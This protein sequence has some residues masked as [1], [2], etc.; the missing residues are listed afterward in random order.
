MFW[1]RHPI[2][3]DNL[4]I[5]VLI[6]AYVLAVFGE[7]VFLGLDPEPAFRYHFDP[8]A[9][10]AAVFSL[11]SL[12]VLILTGSHRRYLTLR[13]LG[14]FMVV[15]AF[16]PLFTSSF[17]TCKQI[18]PYIHPFTWDAPL[19]RLDYLVHFGN[20]PWKLFEWMFDYPWLIRGIDYAYMLWFGFI[21]LFTVWM[22]WTSHRRIRLC[23]FLTTVLSWTFL[24]S[25]LGTVF[26][27]AGPCYYSK[28]ADAASDPFAPLMSRLEDVNK[29]TPL[30]AIENQT[31]LW[32]ASEQREW[33]P[34][35]GVSAMPS[36]HVAMAAIFALAAFRVKRWLGVFFSGYLVLIQ[37]GA[38]ILGW[39]YAV[40]G[41]FSIVI[42]WLIWALISWVLNRY[43]RD[44][45]FIRVDPR[46][47]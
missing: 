12:A 45:A 6:S 42:T 21:I 26:S 27:S 1:R 35:G 40:D 24:G 41:Y 11:A 33:I 4:P 43:Q 32:E 7:Q 46:Y 34:Y 20:H 17:N 44:P 38:V 9:R 28:V 47:E 14:G 29:R 39:H 5:V 10:I 8:F 13:Y 23:F 30:Y 25:F 37:I 36:I 18:I 22:A 3:T 16:A 2:A 15:F 31:G 19:M